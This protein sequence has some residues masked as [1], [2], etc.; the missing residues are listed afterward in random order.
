MNDVIVI[1]GPTAVGKSAIGVQLAKLINGEIISADSMQIYKHL[2]IGSAKVTNQEMQGIK[3]YLIDIKDPNED[4][5]VS[6]F[7]DDAN[8]CIEEIISKG[9]TPIIVG[10]TGLY[11]K[12]LINGYD[13]AKVNKQTNF[14]DSLNDLTNEEIYDKILKI[15]STT[16]V[17]KN[18]RHRLIRTLEKLVF[19]NGKATKNGTKYN[20]K[21]FAIVDDRQKIYERIN[22]R[23]DKMLNA[24][25]L[26]EAKYL[27]SLNLP[28][29]N[30]AMKAI[31]YKEIFPYLRGKDT[32]ENCLTLLKQKSRN[33]AKRQFTFLNQFDEIS[34]INFDGVENSA[35]KIY[36]MLEDN[37]E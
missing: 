30:L 17:D 29:D 22:A 9:K 10:G 13:F 26:D 14:R 1:Y 27:L 4:Y 20:F 21:L 12:S 23:V 24:G 32:L 19:G 33:Y 34:I 36:K 6:D 16:Q 37:N 5:S 8:K 11:I 35:N 28:E 15:D 3:H 25:L 18:N 7:C 31:G 2:N